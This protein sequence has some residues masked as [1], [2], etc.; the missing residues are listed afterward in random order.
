VD[1]RTILVVDDEALIRALAVETL[2]DAGYTVLEAATGNDAVVIFEQHPEIDV[3]F[4]DIV[5]P[6]IDGFMLA[7]MAKVIRPAVRI[8]Y[9]TG[10]AQ[11][12]RDH[13][14]VVHGR[15]LRKPYH[16]AELADAI[17]ATLAASIG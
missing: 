10:F 6:G 2:R 3:V 17:A 7:D 15:I 13:L 12:T 16:Q 8:L 14:G 5:M 11:R 1:R 9:A 4:T